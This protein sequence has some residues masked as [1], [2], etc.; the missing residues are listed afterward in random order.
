MRV[1]ERSKHAGG[2][3]VSQVSTP[4]RTAVKN[5]EFDRNQKSVVSGDY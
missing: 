3:T 1:A 4:A 2:A 5:D